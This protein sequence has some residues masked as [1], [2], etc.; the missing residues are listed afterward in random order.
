[1]ENIY[2][3]ISV[4]EKN[5]CTYLKLPIANYSQFINKYYQDNN[6]IDN[7]LI[8]RPEE[9]INYLPLFTEFID[10]SQNSKLK[11]CYFDGKSLNTINDI[12]TRSDFNNSN[13]RTFDISV[14]KKKY[15]DIS[16]NDILYNAKRIILNLSNY[17]ITIKEKDNIEQTF[18]PIENTVLKDYFGGKILI[19]EIFTLNNPSCISR[20]L[21]NQE[22][23]LEI[24]CNTVPFE[25][26][27]YKIYKAGLDYYNHLIHHKTSISNLYP[28]TNISSALDTA[29]FEIVFLSEISETI[30]ENKNNEQIR[31]VYISNLKLLIS[32]DSIYTDKSEYIPKYDKDIEQTIKILNSEVYIYEIIDNNSYLSDRFINIYHKPIKITKYKDISRENGLYIYKLKNKQKVYVNFTPIEE[33]DNLSYIFKSEE[34]ASKRLD[35]EKIY[36]QYIKEKDKELREQEI[37][38]KELEKQNRELKFKH[39]KEIEEFKKE[40]EKENLE[41]KIKYEK[42]K[43]ENE[44]KVNRLKEYYEEK[45]YRRKDYYEEKRYERDDALETLKTIGAVAGVVATGFLIYQKIK[46]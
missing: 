22:N 6:K 5:I 46:N 8:Y 11:L 37:K 45:N 12:E 42:M 26:K 43:Y 29:N 13:F 9:F 1:L 41:L 39:E 24:K 17:I 18:F 27:E 2:K 3:T 33:I 7:P 40:Y 30:F 28:N 32:I 10:E 4:A 15:I 25:S 14:K 31:N 34:E 36:E 35:S 19:L 23:Y 16:K 38:L 44:E 20:E 21:H